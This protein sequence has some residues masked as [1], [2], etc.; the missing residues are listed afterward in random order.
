MG[1]CYD[2]CFVVFYVVHFFGEY[3][4][5]KKM[6]NMSDIKF[7]EIYLKNLECLCFLFSA[8]GSIVAECDGDIKCQVFPFAHFEAGV[9]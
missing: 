5:Y 9:L 4:E 3:I 1:T 2:L 7:I 6:H 8:Y